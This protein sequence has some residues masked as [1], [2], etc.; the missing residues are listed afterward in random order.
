MGDA[1]P[2]PAAA[3][4]PAPAGRGLLSRL[5]TW[6][7]VLG[8]LAAVWWLA[9]ERNARRFTL[10]TRD[11]ALVVSR[12]RFFPF[13]ARKL[14]P[15]D[16]ELWRLYAPFPL[17]AGAKA[18]PGGEYDDQTQLDRALFTGAV[19]SAR[20]AAQK[21]DAASLAQAESLAARASQLPGLSPS[22]QDE[23]ASL[24]GELALNAAHGDAAS[25]LKLIRSARARLDAARKI[26]GDR[27]GQV[28]ALV[29]AFDD[30]ARALDPAA[31]GGAR[32]AQPEP[33]VP[34][35]TPPTPPAAPPP[36][37]APAAPPSASPAPA[38]APAP[39]R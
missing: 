31:Q 24:R 26:G 30:A 9:S 35:E 36:Q 32:G 29:A 4:P 12:G 18:L 21:A 38:P 28:E 25:A 15:E 27:V 20:Q 37:S 8:L 11:N 14:G 22:Q 33:A 10:E 17:P 34:A 6:L 39:A 19:T 3:P 16:G 23:L 1:L 2:P 7:L 13:G 5:F